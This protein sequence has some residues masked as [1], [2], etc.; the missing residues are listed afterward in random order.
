MSTTNTR[1]NRKARQ[2]CLYSGEERQVIEVYKEEYR[3]QL[4]KERRGHIFKTKILPDILNFWTKGGTICLGEVEVT[5]RVKV[6][7]GD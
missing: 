2:P 7:D 5:K 6:C 3:S 4:T 1:K